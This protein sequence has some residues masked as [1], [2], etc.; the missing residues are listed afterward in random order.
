MQILLAFIFGAVFGLLA[1]YTL[2]GRD[3]RGPALAPMVGAVVGGLVWLILTWAGLT[4]EN[5]W[6]W[7]ASLAA[8]LIVVYAMVPILTTVRRAH[9][10]RDRAR[11]KVS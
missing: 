8:P 4:V 6:L 1:H 11:L 7:V 10:A 9:D 2:P 3:T 5:G